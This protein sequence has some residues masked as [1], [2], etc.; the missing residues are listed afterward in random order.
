MHLAQVQKAKDDTHS[1]SSSEDK[2]EWSTTVYGSKEAARDLPAHEMREEEMP[3]HIA[4][5]LIHDELALD[6]NPFLNLASFV[7]TFMEPEAEKLMQEG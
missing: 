5:R 7:T 4:Y 2:Q 3:S 1:A 6:G